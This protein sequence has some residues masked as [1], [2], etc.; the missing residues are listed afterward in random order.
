MERTWMKTMRTL[1]WSLLAAA[2]AGGFVVALPGCE[3]LVDFDR[4]KIP[5]D[6]A[7]G[8]VTLSDGGDDSTTPEEAS[9]GDGGGDAGS[10]PDATMSGT[11]GGEGSDAT[12]DTGTG[13]E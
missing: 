8:D 3:L 12:T 5:N 11:D 9:A 13:E 2:V 6:A 4:S 1:K 10:S 7:L